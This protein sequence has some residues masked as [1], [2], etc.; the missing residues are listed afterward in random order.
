VIAR[1][2]NRL[3]EQA[4]DRIKVPPRN[5]FLFAALSYRL[6]DWAWQVG[7]AA[8]RC[9]RRVFTVTMPEV[10]ADTAMFL[11]ERKRFW[12]R[13]GRSSWR[14]V[15]RR[16][17]YELWTLEIR[18]RPSE[19]ADFVRLTAAGISVHHDAGSS[20]SSPTFRSRAG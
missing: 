2:A 9:E 8:E 6:N 20:G 14:S 5:A 18:S 17:R 1:A 19:W 15:A 7:A 13:W 16:A 4:L 12:Q 3:R 11:L 10:V